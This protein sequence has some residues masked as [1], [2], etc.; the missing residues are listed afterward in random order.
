MIAFGTDAPIYHRPLA[1]AGLIVAQVLLF[2]ALPDPPANQPEKA[3][4]AV[5][6]PRALVPGD[7]NEP[8]ERPAWNEADFA[9]PMAEELPAEA[10]AAPRPAPV[11][12]AGPSW[13]ELIA[14]FQPRLQLGQIHPLQWFTSPLIHDHLTCLVINM[15]GLWALGLV[16]EGKVGHRSFLLL[17]VLLAISQAAILQLLS[18]MFGWGPA[19][20]FGA[21]PTILGLLG[22]AAIWAPKNSFDV[23]FGFY[24]G[25]HE[26]PILLYGFLQAA[27]SVLAFG[28]GGSLAP[29]IAL[30]LGI[31][32][33]VAWLRRGWVDCE[34]WDLFSV[35]RNDHLRPRQAE[36]EE[37]LEREAQQLVEATRTYRETG[38]RPTNAASASGTAG[39]SAG[40]TRQTKRSSSPSAPAVGAVEDRLSP[41]QAAQ[42]DIAELIAA[43]N[44]QTALKM[45]DKL[46]RSDSQVELPQPVLGQLMR[47]LLKEQDYPNA[48]AIMQEH[49]ARFAEGRAAVQ[50]ALCKTLLHLERPKKALS[51]LRGIDTKQL[52]QASRSAWGRLAAIAK[53]QIDEGVIELSE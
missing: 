47:G 2:L 48:I 26:V 17:Y 53:Q 8:A 50:L 7:Q 25:T 15:I 39:K 16:I 18:W 9:D 31:P 4:I 22:I 23:W 36:V 33:G 14:G 32:L 52:D 19:T 29:L 13:A 45:M 40:R 24:F 1:T 27:I 20:T 49:I 30:A 51:I 37:E 43:Q 28:S 42:R 44:Y 5:A 35:W 46:R 38:L 41:M 34:G 6:R 11:R 12:E 3:A 10:D 21:A